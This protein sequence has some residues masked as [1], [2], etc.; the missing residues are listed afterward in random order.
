[1]IETAYIHIGTEKTGTTT[2]QDFLESNLARLA[3]AGYATLPGMGERNQTRLAAYAMTDDG[4]QTDLHVQYGLTGPAEREAFEARVEE[5]LAAE[6]EA[7]ADC[8]SLI[9][10]SEHLQSRVRSGEG[11]AKLKALLER[12]VK[13]VRIIVY[14][15]RQ[16]R[17]AVSAF[18]TRFKAG[19]LGTDVF[20]AKPDL[21]HYFDHA[22]LLERWSGVFGRETMVVRI[23]EPGRLIAGDLI[24]DFSDALGLELSEAYEVPK[25]HNRSLNAAALRFL[26]EFNKHAPRIVD[27]RIDTS[28]QDVVESLETHY[29]GRAELVTRAQA[30]AFYARFAAG[31]A[32]ILA[33]YF[34]ESGRTALFDDDFSMYPDAAETADYGFEDAV[35]IAA[36]VWKDTARRSR[37]LRAENAYLRGHLSKCR[38]EYSQAAQHYRNAISLHDA[39]PAAYE[40]AL[41]SALASEVPAG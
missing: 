9:V 1:M 8:H 7:Q 30:E 14:L 28:R 3:E 27:G 17:M 40:E 19:N 23:F 15:R 29:A 41:E 35:E 26:A 39:P 38:N 11:V 13:Q 16:D 5:D 32:V 37:R 21:P 33:E 25:T 4:R 31:N 12:H 36:H 24:A 20:P 6:L 2:I 22:A 18:S 34:A 10:S